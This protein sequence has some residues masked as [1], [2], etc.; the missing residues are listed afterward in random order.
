MQLTISGRQVDIN[1][2][3]RAHIEDRLTAGVKKYFDRAIEAQVQF[4]RARHVC[5]SDISVHAGSGISVQSQ[6]EADDME[7][8][9]DIAA[10]RVEKRLRRFKRRL[11]DHHRAGAPRETMA[12]QFV[13]AAD[14]EDSEPEPD[15]AAGPVT[16]AET[17]TTLHTLTVSEAVMRLELA[18]LPVLVFRNNAHGGVNVVYRRTD[19]N[20]GWIDPGEHPGER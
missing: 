20:I 11:I 17:T 7:T 8:A 18:E 5:R 16:I 2:S 13:L 19:G 9:F 6:G 12:R 4:T 1:D 3:L 15:G 14:T 10:D